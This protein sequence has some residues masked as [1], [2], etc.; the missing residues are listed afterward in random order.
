[1]AT[2]A[3]T[4][5]QGLRLEPQD[6]YPHAVDDVVNFNESVYASGWA[7]LALAAVLTLAS[8]IAGYWMMGAFG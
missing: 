4:A 6:E 2:F 7:V 1:M 5:T 8:W 3:E